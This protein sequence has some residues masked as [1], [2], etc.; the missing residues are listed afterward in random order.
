VYISLYLSSCQSVQEHSSG[1]V[2]DEAFCVVE[3][4][5]KSSLSY[6]DQYRFTPR[7]RLKEESE[8]EDKTQYP[9]K[10]E[11]PLLIIQLPRS[12]GDE[13][14]VPLPSPEI[15]NSLEQ[16]KESEPQDPTVTQAKETE[17]EVIRIEV[18]SQEPIDEA[19]IE[20]MQNETSEATSSNTTITEDEED[21]S[22]DTALVVVE[23]TG[24]TDS[25]DTIKA[26]TGTPHESTCH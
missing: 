24:D 10:E 7:Q 17:P 21:D 20:L 4:Y 26:S 23:P 14:D 11:E 3:E 25:T 15:E 16:T 8:I 19:V 22:Y 12:P 5:S 9:A 18:S 2:T 1:N 13:E 6:Y